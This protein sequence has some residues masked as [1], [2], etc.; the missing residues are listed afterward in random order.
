VRR[1]TPVGGTAPLAGVKVVGTLGPM[2]ARRA[3]SAVLVTAASTVAA[4]ASG[5]LPAHAENGPPPPA[6][7]FGE[8]WGS[9]V[10][11]DW[12]GDL[13]NPA[14]AV[15]SD[16]Y[17]NIPGLP[18]GC[19]ASFCPEGT[20]KLSPYADGRDPET[21]QGPY[22][23]WSWIDGP[24][25]LVGA[26]AEQSYTAAL[27]GFI[28]PGCVQAD[29]SKLPAPSPN[30]GGPGTGNNGVGLGN[31]GGNGTTNQGLG[32]G[33]QAQV[34]GV[35]QGLVQVEPSVLSGGLARTPAVAQAGVAGQ[36]PIVNVFAVEAGTQVLANGATA[37]VAQSAGLPR[38]GS[39]PADVVAVAVLLVGAG[40]VLV[41]GSLH[42]RRSNAA[43]LA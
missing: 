4:L 8:G 26:A 31:G 38:T 20:S 9:W 30:P 28:P 11:F 6:C 37:P 17:V 35:P 43:P 34:P 19:F 15:P 23:A 7:P 33:P 10:A 13:A 29:G 42:R 22:R 18:L 1:R 25:A 2:S 21:V 5:A 24:P 36:T 12:P 41:G 16:A 27:N 32:V 3:L 40:A 39:E 14:T